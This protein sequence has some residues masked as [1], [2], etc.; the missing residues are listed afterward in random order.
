M[1]LIVTGGGTGGHL[2][3][4]IALALAMQ[5][6]IPATQVMFIGTS[7]ILDQEALAGLGFALKT[8]ECSGVKGMSVIRKISSL[9]QLP[10]AVLAAGKMLRAFQPDLVFGV[11]GY[12]T[13]PVLLAAWLLRIP[14]GIHE[15]NSVP[16][17]ANRFAGV[18]AGKIC[19]SIPCHPSFP[20]RKTVRTGNPVRPEILDAASK[21]TARTNSALTVLVLGGSQG[22]HRVN[23]LMLESVASLIATCPDIRIIHQT[24]KVDEEMVARE[25]KRLAVNAQVSAFIRDMASAYS[26][27][28]LVVSRAG[29]TTLAELAVMGLPA[30]LIPF[31]YAADNH[32]V[33]N[34][35]YYENGRGCIVLE[36]AGLTSEI[37]ARIMSE[38]LHNLQELHTMAGNM[39]K[40][41]Q[42]DAADIIVDELCS[43]L[44]GSGYISS[45]KN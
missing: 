14:I 20:P 45:A 16:G 11:G 42:L 32:Q 41:A 44:D 4:G 12:V 26:Q 34:G 13:G 17:L 25:Y 5:R 31:P 27:A 39:R 1:R 24:G 35:K 21:K 36:Q 7:R 15:Q 40:M 38:R 30:V 8:L 29:A 22:A 3:P 19:I 9:L 23:T 18:L 2:F 37:L 10:G 33:T 43:L 6:R 28:D